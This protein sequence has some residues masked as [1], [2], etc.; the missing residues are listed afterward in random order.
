MKTATVDDLENRLSVVLGWL[1]SG[2]DVVVKAPAKAAANQRT[3]AAVDWTQSGAFRDRTGERMLTAEET[4]E[5]YESY[6]GD[7]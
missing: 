4:V 7:D 6:K 5:L 3:E 2:E 1:Q